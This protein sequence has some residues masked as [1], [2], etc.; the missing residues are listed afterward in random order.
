MILNIF[1]YTWEAVEKKHTNDFEIIVKS[2]PE[3]YSLEYIQSFL[4]NSSSLLVSHS[5]VNQRL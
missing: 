4:A 2:T 3:K 1:P 5:G